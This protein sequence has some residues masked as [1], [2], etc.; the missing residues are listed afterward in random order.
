MRIIIPGGSGLIGKAL[1]KAL[2]ADGHET[3][4]LSRNPEKIK[5]APAGVRLHQ[6]DGESAAGWRD[7]AQGDYAL[8]NLAGE[9]IAQ[10]WSKENRQAIRHSRV[11]AG[12]AILDV[13][14]QAETKPRVLIQSSAVGY[15]GTSTGDAPVTESFSPGDDFLSKI[16]FDWEISTAPASKL[17]I[18]RPIIRTGIVLSTEGGALPQ[19]LLPFKLFAGGPVGSGNQWYPWIHIDDEVRAIQFLLANDKADGPFNLTAPNPMTNKEFGKTIG[20][21][22]GR[23]AVMP[24]PGFAMKALFGDMAL[25]LLEGQRAVPQKLL[26]LGFTFKF[27]TALAALRNLLGAAPTAPTPPAQSNSAP[28]TAEKPAVE[29]VAAI[30]E[31]KK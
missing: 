26:G 28:M 15:Y 18:R 29:K 8:V 2:V 22:M 10:R 7:L 5:A 25:L 17:G 12:K 24:A 20:T 9:T 19:Q 4:V 1:S 27:E 30:D 13:I 14:N 3:I 23:P 21:V 11:A 16:C 6:W 31:A